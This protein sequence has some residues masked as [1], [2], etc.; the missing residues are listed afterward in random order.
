MDAAGRFAQSE[1]PAWNDQM[2]TIFPSIV[3]GCWAVTVSTGG[4]TGLV[5][6]EAVAPR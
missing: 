5:I 6:F 1:S 2:G 4:R 3:G